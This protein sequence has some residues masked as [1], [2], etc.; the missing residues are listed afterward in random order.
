MVWGIVWYS[1]VDD[2]KPGQLS[3]VLRSKWTKGES[4]SSAVSLVEQAVC[5]CLHIANSLSLK[6][7]ASGPAR[8]SRRFSGATSD[9]ATESSGLLLKV[10]QVQV[11]R[12]VLPCLAWRYESTRSI[13]CLK[14]FILAHIAPVHTILS[15]TT[16][17]ICVL[18]ITRLSES[19][20]CSG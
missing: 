17:E 6:P 12:S 5:F 18:F 1:I 15:T 7:T 2:T 8:R 14:V 19:I 3:K 9:A 16:L 20:W 10:L 4:H 11:S 13:L